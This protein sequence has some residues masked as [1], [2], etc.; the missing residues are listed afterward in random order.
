[1]TLHFRKSSFSG[2]M[3]NCVEVAFRKSTFSNP[4]GECV[5][6]AG[7]PNGAVLVRDTKDN[8]SGP[9]LE[10]TQA[11]WDAFMHGAKAGEFD[12]L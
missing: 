5:E 2:V 6:V 4:N 10:F 11:E 1:M 3:G 9:V 12:S 8:G 7:G